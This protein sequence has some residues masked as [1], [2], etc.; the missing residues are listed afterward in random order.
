MS[1]GYGFHWTPC[2]PGPAGGG[3]LVAL[4]IAAVVYGARNQIAQAVGDLVLLA[5]VVVVAVMVLGIAGGFFLVRHRRREAEAI[6]AYREQKEAEWRAE[7]EERQARRLAA[8]Q[9]RAL[10]AAQPIQIINVIDP[11]LLASL[12]DGG[13]Q[14]VRV[15]PAS[16]EE[17]PR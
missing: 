14:A 9:A 12:L 7:V 17:V 4:I 8:Q 2:K 16:T 15:I 1:H 13:Q 3:A 11:A 10:P 5:M 6:A